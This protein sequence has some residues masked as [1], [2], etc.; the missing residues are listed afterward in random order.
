MSTCISAHR[1]CQFAVLCLAALAM[2]TVTLAQ[3]IWLPASGAVNRGMGGATTGTAIEAI[4][5]MYWN[6]A[7]ISQLETNEMA[8]GFECIYAN[9][10]LSST[11]P[12]VGSGASHG[13]LGVMPVP[14]MAWVHHTANPNV[15]LGLG[16]FG[17][18]GFN[19]NVRA[20]A[21][22]PIL[23]PP[24]AQ[25]GVGMGGIKAEAQFFQM[26]P[27]I[28]VQVTDR[29]SIAAG[30]VASL[31]R[32]ISDGNVFAGLNAN[33]LYPYGDGTRYHWGLGGQLGFHYVHN[34]CWEFGG[35]IKSP[36][37][38]EPFRYFGE[39]ANGLG[40]TDKL[41]VTLPM[42]LTGGV[43]YRG[44]DF[45]VL[46]AD[47]RYIDYTSTELFGDPAAYRP[48]GGVTGL[49]WKD[50]FSVAVGSE[51]QLTDRLVGRMGYIFASNIIDESTT[52]FNVASDLGWQHVPAVGATFQF[53]ENASISFA[54]NYVASWGS[55]GPYVLPGVGAL[56]GTSVTT[57]T[58]AHIGTLGVNVKY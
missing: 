52:F 6:P 2:P 8:F 40:R 17:V 10:E 43:A 13:E 25:G 14:T 28:S 32:I 7:T 1:V 9:Q 3:G 16:I 36:T 53:T 5:S 33:G 21:T 20:D 23:S 19:T 57:Q 46:T 26:N 24:L 37:W 34:C 30:P 11:F 56:P 47:V 41:N 48:D 27:A 12:G 31:G 49:G 50:A 45:M 54:Y 38:F 29:L 15:T 18:G 51:V 55:T 35:N 58:D 42:V 39:D 22:N 4:G 44:F